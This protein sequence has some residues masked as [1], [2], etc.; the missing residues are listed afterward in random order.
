M[1]TF[2]ICHENEALNR[3]ALPRWLASFSTLAG[4]IV[5]RETR[6][7]NQRRIQREM[8]RVGFLRFLDVLAFRLY[9][10]TFLEAKDRQWEQSQLAELCRRYPEIPDSTPI[11]VSASPNT[12]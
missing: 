8:K 6:Q 1:R 11:L 2:L 10:A 7:Q 5:L 3:I 9:Y 4:M 12:H